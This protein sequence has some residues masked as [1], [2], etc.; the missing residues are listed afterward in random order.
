M[1]SET[2]YQILDYF[3]VIFHFS[4]ILFNLAGWIW[5]KT[6]KL[7]LYVISATIFSWIGLGFFY[8]WGY[9]P[10]TDWHWQVK[11][12]LGV[13]GLPASY[14]KYYLD[15]VFGY[16]WDPSTVDILVAVLGIGAFLISI[17]LN[18]RD[19]QAQKNQ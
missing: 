10:C 2:T 17:F 12:E 4:L 3:F 16:S 13:T 7:H 5:Q 9:C 8:G 19:W 15:Q 14:I 6:R 11:R 18:Y 1:L